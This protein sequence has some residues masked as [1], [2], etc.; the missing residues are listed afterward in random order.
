[1]TKD[2]I[3]IVKEN[4]KRIMNEKGINQS[5]LEE[6]TGIPQ[7]RIS[8]ALS[9]GNG[10]CFTTE[11]IIKLASED[12]FNC[13]TD[14]ILLPPGN[15]ENTKNNIETVSDV[16]KM[17]FEIDEFMN[18]NI[19]WYRVDAPWGIN[20]HED[21]PGIC[22][23]STIFGK[24]LNEWRQLK[25][26]TLEEPLKSKIIKQWQQDTLKLYKNCKKEDVT[27]NPYDPYDC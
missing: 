1:M 18:L 7:S 17:L 22:S 3:D 19:E 6:R 12:V 23:Y 4:I 27:E 2:N 11:Q 25:E 15:E 9:F 24:I 10:K 21:M 5:E 14:E 8:A 16:F 13:S 26:T 20:G